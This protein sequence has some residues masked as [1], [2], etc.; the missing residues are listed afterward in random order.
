[1]VKEAT[2]GLPRPHYYVAGVPDMAED[3]RQMLDDDMGIDDDTHTEGLR[4]RDTDVTR[5]LA[6]H[7]ANGALQKLAVAHMAKSPGAKEGVI[8]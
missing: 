7:R 3:M 6:I 4:L 1:M 8:V 5:H 2:S